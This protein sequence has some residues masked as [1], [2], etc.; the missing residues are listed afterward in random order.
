[1][2]NA[3]QLIFFGDSKPP[4]EL[5]DLDNDPHE[6]HNLAGDPEY[7]DELHE[8][9]RL[10][11]DWIAQTGDQ[12]QQP[13][14]EVGLRCVL[15]RW[16]DLCVNPEYEPV[17]AKME[18]E[19]AARK[20]NIIFVLCDDLGWG[21]LS[22]HGHPVI[23]TPHIDGLARG[24]IR[25]TNFYSAAPVCSPSRV[26]LMT[27]R[28]PNRAGVYDWIPPAGQARSDAREQVHMRREE[29]TI[30]QLLKTAGYATCMA[31][32][33]HCNSAFNSPTQPQ[34]G[35]A[36][37]DHWL[38]TQNNAG[39][40]HENPAN[41]VR[42]GQAV[43]KIDGYS[44]QIAA[45]EVISWIQHQQKSSNE[46][47]FFAYLAFHEPHEPVASPPELVAHYRPHCIS[48]D[49]AQFFANVHNVDLAVGRVL[50]SL[51]EL[52]IRNQTLVVFSSDNGPE[53][54]NRYRTANRSWGVTGHL[55][56]MKLHTHDGGFHVAGIMNW[57]AGIPAGVVCDQPA[58][59]LD[60]LPTFAELAGATLPSGRQFDGMSLAEFFRSG[61]FPERSQPLVW[62]Y[63]NA[64]N[65]AR[66]A[67][68]LGPWKV[69]ARLD[70]G[71]V[72]KLE[73]LIPR[74]REQVAN[75]ALTDFEVYR[76]DRDPG[77]TT[78]LAGRGDPEA[79]L[80]TQ[81]LDSEYRALVHDSPAWT[82]VVAP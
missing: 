56:G 79:D 45:S 68:R 9:R 52:Q 75:A 80:M 13:E 41:Y 27:G 15:K 5:Y 22:I 29:L 60:L 21:D 67:M 38:A 34:P 58:S 72:P 39:P 6:I 23:T 25:F 28:S 8:Q 73:N 64:V 76:V 70:R 82:P 19:A 65:D 31:G 17:R 26:G 40:S 33:W 49:Q 71:S 24:G 62:A 74:T 10:L 16:G 55:R 3:T 42:N 47:P 14:S 53:T 30:P 4:E 35:D 57:P 77:E 44:C 50:E 1:E 43:G 36:G 32:K 69:L 20:P 78:N 51:Q 7:A 54:L 12:G 2:M 46:Q 63:Y 59:S 81:R 61:G 66:V 11:A 18:A 37:F 48:E